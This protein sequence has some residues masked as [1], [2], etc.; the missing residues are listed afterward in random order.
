[1]IT[2]T[3]SALI[4]SRTLRDSF[5]KQEKA[6]LI[7]E[8]VKALS[9]LPDDLNATIEMTANYYE[10]YKNTIELLIADHRDELESDGLRVLYGDELTVLKTVGAISK[11]TPS[12]TIVPRRAILRFGMLLRV[13]EVAK[14]VRT[15]LLDAEAQT[16]QMDW[17]KVSRQ[18][19]A[20]A[21]MH[22]M[23]GKSKQ[24][25]FRLAV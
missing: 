25:A 24:E 12:L 3:D 15:S 10:V 22:R 4:E 9:L 5:T 11:N 17:V 8:K 16:K 18:I 21:R 13:G 2:I 23:A 1:M 6:A 14:Q 7:L 19:E 20:V